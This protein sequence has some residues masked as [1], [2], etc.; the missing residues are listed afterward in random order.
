MLRRGNLRIELFEVSDY[1]PA[2]E[3]RRSSS[4]D[5][6]AQ[7]NKYLAF[8]VKDVRAADENLRHRGA[9]ILFIQDFEWG[10]SAFIRDN[11]GNVIELVQESKL[12]EPALD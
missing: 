10:S 2:H 3:S 4:R 9:D 7:G 12:W 8:S 6:R 5:L 11:V 1:V